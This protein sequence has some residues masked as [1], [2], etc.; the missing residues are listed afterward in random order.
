MTGRGGDYF[1]TS[2]SGKPA[3]GD[4]RAETCEMRRKQP[5]KGLREGTAG[6]GSRLYKGWTRDVEEQV[7]GCSVCSLLRVGKR[8]VM[9]LESRRGPVHAR[10]LG[11]GQ[12][13]ALYPDGSG[14][15]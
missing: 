9:R 3:G 14:K 1:L 7:E 10:S 4:I 12:A 15:S 8:D 11:Q 5:Q 6:R 2:C 13:F